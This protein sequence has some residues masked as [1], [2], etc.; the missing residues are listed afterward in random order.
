MTRDPADPHNPQTGT[1]EVLQTVQITTEGMKEEACVRSIEAALLQHTAI[2][3][4]RSDLSQAL[5]TVTFDARR[6]HPPEIHDI[7]LGTGYQPAGLV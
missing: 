1:E 3:E 2:K 4:V 5:V 6:I 7:I